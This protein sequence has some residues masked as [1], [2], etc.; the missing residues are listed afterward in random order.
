MTASRRKRE[1]TANHV[2]RSRVEK[3]QRRAFSTACRSFPV[4]VSRPEN[5][6]EAPIY[7]GLYHLH[8]QA[9]EKHRLSTDHARCMEVPS[10][11]RWRQVIKK[12]R[13]P[14]TAFAAAAGIGSAATHSPVKKRGRHVRRPCRPRERKRPLHVEEFARPWAGVVPAAQHRCYGSRRRMEGSQRAPSTTCR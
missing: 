2:F 8:Q 3:A 6:R 10:P 14:E 13:S 9:V 4:V 1:G 7:P 11:F 12:A 5:N